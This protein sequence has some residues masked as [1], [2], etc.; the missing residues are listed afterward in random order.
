LGDLIFGGLQTRR[1]DLILVGCIAAALLALVLDFAIGMAQQ[2][3]KRFPPRSVLA[4]VGGVLV[5]TSLAL[6]VP[7]FRAEKTLTIGAKSFTEQ[8][9]L[10]EIL[11]E[12]LRKGSKSTVT[13]RHSLGSTVAFDALVAGDLDAYVDYS[14]TIWATVLKEKG[15]APG[16]EVALARVKEALKRDHGVEVVAALGFENTYA[17]A[18]REAQAEKL[19]LKSLVDLAGKSAALTIGSDYE[20]F[21][22]PEWKSLESTYGLAFSQQKTMDPTFMY[23]AVKNADVDVISAYSTDGRI[24]SFKLRVLADPKGAIPPYDAIVLIRAGLGQAEKRALAALTGKI[25]GDAM[26]KMNHAVDAAKKNPRDVARAF[27][28]GIR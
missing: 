22:R 24:E 21:S 18:M 7:G 23:E 20:F 26:R 5:A 10:S 14:G 1:N 12:A 17:L 19:G 3:L 28:K 6:S 2:A 8:Y 16:R 13:T 11:A 15:N 4:T 9:I 27:L 25:S